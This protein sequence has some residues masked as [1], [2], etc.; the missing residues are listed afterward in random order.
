MVIIYIHFVELESPILHVKF[1]DHAKFQDQRTLEKMLL[2]SVYHILAWQLYWT[3]VM[4]HLHRLKF[5][6]PFLGGSK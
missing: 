2:K 3:G 6:S 4:D 5:V 1:Q